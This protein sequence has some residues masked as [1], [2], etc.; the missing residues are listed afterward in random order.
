[1]YNGIINMHITA[2]DDRGM[3]NIQLHFN[4]TTIYNE[5][6][7]SDK[8]WKNGTFDFD[9]QLD[10]R[11]YADGSYLF[12]VQGIDIHSNAWEIFFNIEIDNTPIITTL[13]GPADLSNNSRT[14]S[15]R[16]LEFAFSETPQT[17]FYAWDG[18]P[19]STILSPIPAGNGWHILEIWTTDAAGN[20]NYTTFS[21]EVDDSQIFVY[22]ENCEDGDVIPSS[23]E[24]NITFSRPPTEVYYAWDSEPESNTLPPIPTEQGLHTLQ[25]RTVSDTR[26]ERITTFTFTI[27]D[28]PPSITLV[29]PEEFIG[30]NSGIEIQL[31]ISEAY[32]Q[33]IFSWDGGKNFTQNP[34]LPVGNGYHI[35]HVWVADFVPYWTY[36]NFT[37]LTDDPLMIDFITWTNGTVVESNVTIN[38]TIKGT[39]GNYF[40][41]WDEAPYIEAPLGQWPTTPILDGQHSLN[42][43][44]S[45]EDSET[46][47]ATLILIVANPLIDITLLY[48]QNNTI[49]AGYQEIS[50]SFSEDPVI[51]YYSWDG[52][53]N[54]TILTAVPNFD[55]IHTLDVWVLN[56]H[57]SWNHKHFEWLVDVNDPPE[58]VI[59]YPT[60]GEILQGQVTFSWDGSDPDNDPLTY[61]IFI[62]T[63]G[64]SW[65]KI[66]EGLT[67]EVYTFNTNDYPEGVYYLEIHADDGEIFSIA[68][69]Q[70]TIEFRHTVEENNTNDEENPFET[71]TIPGFPI[72]W[73]IIPCVLVVSKIA[74]SYRRQKLLK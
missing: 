41:A 58:V 43:W 21:F 27:D 47:S 44:I 18:A 29:S 74:P 3:K 51:A 73:L 55:G 30:L 31:S 40:Y 9:F 56:E 11:M 12:V 46:L 6:I 17:V 63:D 69:L 7:S 15:G 22:L 16:M 13:I 4:D 8:F 14:A 70:G 37:F 52:Q 39:L 65:L 24:L 71:F 34:I 59:L 64:V 54:S 35:L 26:I 72:I 49:I 25:I 53:P 33:L 28:I 23:F 10:T 42:I 5:D 66:V 50:L 45:D 38:M 1:V 60:G 57:G 32:S 20:A 2:I 36:A 48:P 68:T 61:A 62:S 19:S 67:R